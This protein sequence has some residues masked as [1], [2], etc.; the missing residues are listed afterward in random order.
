MF[1]NTHSIQ[2]ILTTPKFKGNNLEMPFYKD[3]KLL[4]RNERDSFNVKFNLTILK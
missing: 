3:K 4:F 1:K 2:Q